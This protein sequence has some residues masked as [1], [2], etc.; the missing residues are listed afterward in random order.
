[1]N[2]TQI[3]QLL[4]KNRLAPLKQLGQH[5]LIDERAQEKIVHFAQITKDDIIIE[6][7]AGLGILTQKLSG[8]AK[9]V[10]AVEI[11][12]GFAQVLKERF[13]HIPNVEVIPEDI[14]RL[15]ISR[16]LA[17]KVVG[18]LPYNLS[19]KILEKFLQKE[20][21]KPALMVVTVQQEFAKRMVAKPPCMNRLALLCQYYAKLKLLATFPPSSFWPQPKVRSKLLRIELKREP[22]LLPHGQEVKM[23]EKAKR[24]F[25]Q[26]RKMLKNTL[27]ETSNTPFATLRP[28]DLSLN[29]WVSLA[30][31]REPK[32]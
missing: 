7:G 8:Q 25:G 30:L 2:I 11:D 27:L 24:A 10:I 18:N 19:S 13:E 6:V 23:W 9:K 12:K 16:N 29:D 1:M 5:F 17:Y 32:R 20:G 21:Q 22:S 26:P 15:A 4:E 31:T 28:Q 3:K 14:L